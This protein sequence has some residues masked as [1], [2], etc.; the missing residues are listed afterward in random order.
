MGKVRDCCGWTAW[1]EMAGIDEDGR[2]TAT[3]RG[4]VTAPHS[5]VMPSL[6]DIQRARELISDAVVRTPLVPALALRQRV[7]GPLF[8]KLENLQRTG[9]FKDRGALNRLLALSAEERARGVVTASAGNH[10]QAVAYHGARLGIPVQVVMPEHTP[11]IKVTNTRRFGADVRFHGATL[12][13]SITEARRLER[14]ESRILV[15]AFDDERVIAGQGTIGLELLE[16]LDNITAVVVPIGGG[17]LISGIAIALKEQRPSVKVFG[18][19]AAAAPSALASRN[20]GH[21]VK[22]ESADTLADGIAVKRVGERTFPLIERYVDDIV[23]VDE[24]EIAAAVHLLLEQEKVLAEGAG[25]VPLAALIAGKLPIRAE[26]VT[27]MVL[28]GGNIDVNMV[29]RIIARGLVADGRLAMLA[30]TV[31]DRPGSLARLTTLVAAGGANVLQ[32]SHRRAFADISVRD[33][34]IVM[35]L[36][37]RGPDHVKDIVR[38]L[39]QHGFGVRKNEH[40]MTTVL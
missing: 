6:A 11:L 12:D 22:L 2:A 24:D 4:T 33:V 35:Q 23:S 38:T 9:S 28:S 8:L 37:T 19:E 39:E 16:Q 31:P 20:A 17:G 13:E 34:E 21:I 32:L 25:A 7:P 5:M 10:A 14:E 27:V 18:V 36:E 29:E 26:D 15:H 40:S 3:R 1:F 30:V